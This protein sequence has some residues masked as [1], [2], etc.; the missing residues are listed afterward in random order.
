MESDEH[1]QKVYL[2]R[3][4]GQRASDNADD[5]WDMPHTYNF[6]STSGEFLLLHSMRWKIVTQQMV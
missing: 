6:E 1:S 3:N 5:Y 2:F 4:E